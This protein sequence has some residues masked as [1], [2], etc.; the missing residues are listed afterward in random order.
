MGAGDCFDAH[1]MASV[2]RMDARRELRL[3]MG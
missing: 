2:A 1:P 3:F